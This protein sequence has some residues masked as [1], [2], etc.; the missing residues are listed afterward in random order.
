M[1]LFVKLVPA[2]TVA[3]LALSGLATSAHAD[4]TVNGEVGLPLNPTAQVPEQ[5]GVRLQ[6]N[7]YDADGGKLYTLAGAARVGTS[8]LEVSAAYHHPTGDGDPD[9][10]FGVGVKYLFSRESDPAGVRLA[11]GAGYTKIDDLKNTRAYLVASKS[12]SA[13][14]EGKA[15]ITGHLGL[16]YDHYKNVGSS[17]KASVFAGVEVPLTSSGEFQAVGEIGTKIADG[18]KIPYSASLRYRPASQP[19][20]VSLGIQQQGV[21]SDKGRFFAQIGYTFGK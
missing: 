8:P 16:R 14:S 9:D 3:A 21:F 13:I 19:F 6:G 5:K 10:G 20:G 2:C 7:Y 18:A 12:L 11:V 1:R 4:L 17:S 15:P